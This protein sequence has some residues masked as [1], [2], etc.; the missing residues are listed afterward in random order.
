M[1]QRSP[2]LPDAPAP[3]A[4]VLRA[5]TPAAWQTAVLAGFDAFL[6]D[7]A[8]N[9]RKASA[10]ALSLIS[11]YPDRKKLVRAMLDVAREELDHYD[12][13]YRHMEERGLCFQPDSRDPYVGSIRAA[14]RRGRDDYFLDRLVAGAIVE[15]RGQERFA[16]LG[17][18]L[19]DPPL[20]TF[21][22]MLAAS[23]ARHAGVFLELAGD[24]FPASHV[25]D[26]CDALLDLEAE[27][28]GELPV[29]AALH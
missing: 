21:Y 26:R 25:A 1:A 7:H 12:Q 8:A 17:S 22:R 14:L 15:A 24:Y 3:G 16:I 9:E 10:V 2:E 4:I 27:I 11:H 23:E 5:Q 28:V 29:R 18:A 13:V 19:T 6:A 20:R